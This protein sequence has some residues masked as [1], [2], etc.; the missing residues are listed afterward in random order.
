MNNKKRIFIDEI[1]HIIAARFNAKIKAGKPFTTMELAEEI[2][3]EFKKLRLIDIL[4]IG[5]INSIIIDLIQN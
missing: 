4:L 1:H 3:M 2:L 5:A